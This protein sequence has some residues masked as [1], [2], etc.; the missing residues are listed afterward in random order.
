MTPPRCPCCNTD[1]AIGNQ[2]E[3]LFLC[4]TCYGAMAS[5]SW[6]KSNLKPGIVK[7]LERPIE[8]PTSTNFSCPICS[9]K[10][11]TYLTENSI[12]TTSDN[13]I[14][15]D[16][17]ERCKAIWFDNKELNQV[18]PDNPKSFDVPFSENK[19]IFDKILSSNFWSKIL[20]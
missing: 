4:G 11:K 15:I 13:R 12:N 19:G 17:C 2:D 8:E 20:K 7:R 3:L 6:I 14:Q 9:G 18:L 16:R 10:M 1:M 5:N